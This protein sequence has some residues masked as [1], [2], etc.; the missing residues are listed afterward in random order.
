[1][2]IAESVQTLAIGVY[3]LGAVVAVVFIARDKL[4]DLAERRITRRSV[5]VA[6]NDNSKQRKKS[7]GA[8]G[9]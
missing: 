2:G 8:R 7:G 3:A 9:G 4:R 1:M 5:P 6:A